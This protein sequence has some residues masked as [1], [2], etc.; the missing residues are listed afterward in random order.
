MRGISISSVITSGSSARIL[1]RAIYGSGAVAITW[2]AVSG[3]GTITFGN[4]NALATTAS[5]SV[6]GN[7]Q[8]QLAAN[9]GQ[10]TTIGSVTVTAITRPNLS[11]QLL[12]GA[13]QLAWPVNA[14]NWQL[15]YQ[16]NLPTGGLGTNWQNFPGPVTNPFVAPVDPTAGS[17]FYRLLW[18]GN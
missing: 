6:A 15:Q 10:V 13:L 5:F 11:F 16:T 7:Y 3:P 17:V 14:G 2:S 4:S 8:L 1:S 12:P 18:L 9:D